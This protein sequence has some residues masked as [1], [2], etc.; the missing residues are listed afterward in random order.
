MIAALLRL[1]GLG[2]GGVV[3]AITDIVGDLANARVLLANATTEQERIAAQADVDRHSAELA[4]AQAL[5]AAKQQSPWLSLPQIV[6]GMSFAIY[7]A[8]LLVWDKVLGWGAT[9]PLTGDLR[10]WAFVILG[11]YFLT[12]IARR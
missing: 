6:M 8:K 2:G 4:A 12:A 9:D 3:R 10:D 7:V 5:I 11:G 1:L